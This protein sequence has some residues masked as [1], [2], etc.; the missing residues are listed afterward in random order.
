[1]KIDKDKRA[2]VAKAQNILS[3]IAS[4]LKASDGEVKKKVDLTKIAEEMA[5]RRVRS[6][7]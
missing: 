5:E 2:S 6:E 4:K 7:E 1:M 3:S